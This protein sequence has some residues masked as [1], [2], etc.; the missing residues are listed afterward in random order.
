MSLEYKDITIKGW[1]ML[2]N[3][4]FNGLKRGLEQKDENKIIRKMNELQFLLN[5][6]G[7]TE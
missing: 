5:K 7:E 3:D 1:H 2:L 6:M 4:Q